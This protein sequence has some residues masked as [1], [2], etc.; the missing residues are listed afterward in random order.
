MD[1]IH[2]RP[3][4]SS[5]ATRSASVVASHLH[6]VALVAA[7]I[8][9]AAYPML[10]G[11]GSEVG[12]AGAELYARPSWLIAHCLG[13]IGFVAA[14]WGLTRV[15]RWAHGLALAGAILVLPYYGAEAFGLNAIG[16]LAIQTGDGGLVA[17]ADLF[18]FQPVAL[19]TFA[20][21]LLLVLAAGVRLLVLLRM[22]STGWWQR[23]GLLLAGLG[24]IGYL[25]Q[26]FG[27]IE[28]RIAHGI[29]LG[30]GL[31]L[32]ALPITRAPGSDRPQTAALV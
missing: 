11:S 18:R 27:S 1:T 23:I 6:R 12:L 25:P 17:A 20:A 9:Y 5:A 32:L 8:A 16:R 21:G 3:A 7:G 4:E 22:R 15:D 10:R 2:D 29:V 19:T 28:L 26:F 31:I 13:M 24:L 14:A 30:L